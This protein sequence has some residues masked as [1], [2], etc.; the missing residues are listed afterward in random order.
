MY[1]RELV[2]KIFVYTF[3]AVSFYGL[4]KLVTLDMPAD[5]RTTNI[6]YT[7]P[8]VSPNLD[9]IKNDRLKSIEE[10]IEEQ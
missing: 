5:H 4:F 9:L 7:L 3:I 6:Q 2:D 10:R 1:R 8:I